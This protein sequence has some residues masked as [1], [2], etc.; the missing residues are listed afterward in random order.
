[1]IPKRYIYYLRI[2]QIEMMVDLP[3]YGP[4]NRIRLGSFLRMKPLVLNYDGSEKL[5]DFQVKCVLTPSDIPFEKLR[6]DKQDL[7]FMDNNNEPIP[8]WIEK[9]DSTEIVVWLKFSEIIPGKEVFLV[10]LW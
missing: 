10:V 8:Y 6:A 3:S 1:M 4:T 9:T 2:H 5:A 7:L